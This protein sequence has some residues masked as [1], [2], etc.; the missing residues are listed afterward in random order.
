MARQRPGRSTAAQSA[1]SAFTLIELLVVVSIIALL[2]SILLPS[3]GRAR[4]QAKATVCLSHVREVGRAMSYY[5][6][7][8]PGFLPPYNILRPITNTLADSINVPYWFQY[9]PFMY[10]SN[11]TV[12]AQC[13]S[14]KNHE[15]VNNPGTKRGPYRNLQT[16]QATIYCSYTMNPNV[17]KKTD[18][19]IYPRSMAAQL[20]PV[21]APY[22][23]AGVVERFNPG[24]ADRIRRPQQL[25]YLLET[26]SS[27][28]LNPSSPFNFFRTSH[29]S[30][31]DR[32]S[33]L[34]GDTHASQMNI[35]DIYVSDFSTKPPAYMSSA[36][37]HA[38]RAFWYG[39]ERVQG[40]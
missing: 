34:H 16:Q 18:T 29:G 37:T 5:E 21:L 12:V 38:L 20:V 39:D 6:A 3:L 19:P 8:H 15:D 25:A 24:L 23:E 10:L 27:G 31:K 2:I 1:T 17:P 35:R 30:R 22:T 28:L 40:P 32:M 11:S 7:D 36:W 9:L 13:P 26:A 33:I 4:D 14:D